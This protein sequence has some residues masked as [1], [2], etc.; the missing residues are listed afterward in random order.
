MI[1]TH[2]HCIHWRDGRRVNPAKSVSN[3]YSMNP[4]KVD[5]TVM[6]CKNA[7]WFSV[8]SFGANLPAFLLLARAR[9]REK[10]LP[11]DSTE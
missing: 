9:H 7:V 3:N 5:F 11:H 2:L 8:G 6:L 1:Y 10:Y 4:P